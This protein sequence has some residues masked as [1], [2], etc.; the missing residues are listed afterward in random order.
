MKRL[1]I[2][3][4][5]L[6][7]IFAGTLLH[8]RS[9]HGFTDRLS[10]LLGQAEELAE[11]ERWEQA[12]ALTVQARDIWTGRD[13]YLHVLLRHGD[14]DSIYTAFR[15]T[16]A[17]LESREYGEYAAANARLTTQIQLLYEAEQLT[18]KNI[19]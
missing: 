16:L 10:T 17:L 3:L 4:A 1:W 12:A 9:L 7:A 13:V 2:A 8:I 18:L 14:T 11:A 15:E 19:F 6:G 5:L